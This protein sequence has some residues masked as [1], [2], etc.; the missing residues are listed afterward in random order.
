LL[1]KFRIPREDPISWQLG[2]VERE[3]NEILRE[4]QNRRIER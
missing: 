2:L 4:A 1:K 3:I